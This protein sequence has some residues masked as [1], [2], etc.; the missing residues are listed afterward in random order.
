VLPTPRSCGAVDGFPGDTP[1]AEGPGAIEA[2]M[3]LAACD[4]CWRT[5]D[6]ADPNTILPMPQW[7]I[8]AKIPMR[9]VT[10]KRNFIFIKSE[11]KPMRRTMSGARAPP[12]TANTFTLSRNP[13][14]AGPE[15]VLV[16]LLMVSSHPGNTRNRRP[17]TMVIKDRMLNVSDAAARLTVGSLLIITKPEENVCPCNNRIGRD[18]HL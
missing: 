17:M 1:G 4:A 2:A 11:M 7:T 18:E 10:E 9:L 14:D 12:R 5:P 8:T 16:A 15:I 3:L 6:P 13:P